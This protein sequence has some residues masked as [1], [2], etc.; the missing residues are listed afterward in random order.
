MKVKTRM[1]IHAHRKTIE[2]LDGEYSS[3]HHGRSHDFDDLR[4]YAPGDEVKDIDWKATARSNVPLIKR[5]IASRQHN[6]VFVVDTGRGMAAIGESGE[7][8]SEIAIQ[9]VGVLAYLATRH[10]DRAALFTGNS[11]NLDHM[12]QGGS[13]AHIE[14]MLRRI[15]ESIT[16]DSPQSDMTFVLTQVARRLRHR[17]IVF[18]VAD[19]ILLN[20]DMVT[21]LGRLHA[22]H[23]VMWV[24]VGDAD[25]MARSAGAP[26][27]WGVDS[28]A[29]LP[30]FVR[31]SRKL[32]RVFDR[33][34]EQ[35]RDL[36]EGELRKKGVAGVRI[37]SIKETVQSLFRLLERH[38]RASR[39]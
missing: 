4:E 31:R 34:V 39:A 38:R 8:K 26:A 5:Y 17:S 28:K 20:P 18:I 2:L 32:Q 33:G 12:P 24:S 36:L 25:L 10:G 23:E 9:A 15:D 29:E 35:R 22:R 14:R 7:P 3:I 13:E 6:I 37:G 27:V 1:R 19:D 16:L 21:Q 30:D 11:D